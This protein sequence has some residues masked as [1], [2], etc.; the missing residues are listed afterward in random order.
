[1]LEFIEGFIENIVVPL[2]GCE[3]AGRADYCKGVDQVCAEVG[4]YI[5]RQKS[6]SARSILGPV[7]EVAHQFGRRHFWKKDEK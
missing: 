2:I 7:S 4:V 1:M 6:A 3:L 5:G